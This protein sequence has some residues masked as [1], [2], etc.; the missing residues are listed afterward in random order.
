MT[1]ALP[2]IDIRGIC[3]GAAVQSIKS[4]LHATAA[5]WPGQ[6]VTRSLGMGMVFALI[7]EGR[8]D[9]IEEQVS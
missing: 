5:P 6:G 4:A 7:V 3:R 1:T 9:P 8:S 2:G